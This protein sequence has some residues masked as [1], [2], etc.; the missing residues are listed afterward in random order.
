MNFY[1]L[2]DEIEAG[3][4]SWIEVFVMLQNGHIDPQ[5]IARLEDGLE[6]S[7]IENIGLWREGDEVGP[8]TREE[9]AYLVS[10]GCLD[11]DVEVRVEGDDHLQPLAEV[12]GCGTPTSSDV[13]VAHGSD[14]P[15]T[16][17]N[18]I[19]F[20]RIVSACRCLML[21]FE[22]WVLQ[23][24]LI[25]ALTL[26][27]LGVVAGW[28]LRSLFVLP[29]NSVA[30]NQIASPIADAALSQRGVPPGS[31][32]RIGAAASETILP[33]DSTQVEPIAASEET[34]A[35]EEV[36]QSKEQGAPPSNNLASD[37]PE[38]RPAAPISEDEKASVTP[39]LSH[40]IAPAD[41]SKSQE[42][43]AAPK[44]QA[45]NLPKIPVLQPP[46]SAVR[47]PA[48]PARSANVKQL[49]PFETPQLTS[50]ELED[51]L[52]ERF[53]SPAIK[54]PESFDQRP[55]QGLYVY[56][57]SFKLQTKLV[58]NP[59]VEVVYRVPMQSKTRP[60]PDASNVVMLGIYHG[61]IQPQRKKIVDG[62]ALTEKSSLHG[63]LTPFAD[64]LGYTAF[65]FHIKTTPDMSSDRREY[66]AYG[67]SDWVDLVFRAKAEIEKRHKLQEKK[68]L[69]YGVSEGGQF[70]QNIAAAVPDKVAAAVIQ[71]G[72]HIT[73]PNE[74][75]DTA[76]FL[77][78]TRG[79]AMQSSYEA[80]YN[81]LLQQDANVSFNIF[82]PDYG[83]RG[84]GGNFYHSQSVIADLASR[85]FLRG[86]VDSLDSTGKYNRA[87]WPFVRDRSKPLRIYPSGSEIAKKMPNELKEYLPSKAFAQCLQNVPAQMQSVTLPTGGVKRAKAFVGLP[88]MGKP[89]GVILYSQAFNILELQHM[90][91]NIYFL[92]GL[93]Y[94][95]IAPQLKKTDSVD[96]L[97]AMTFYEDSTALEKFP[98]AVIGYG[99]KGNL[100]WDAV[101][102]NRDVLPKAV[103][104]LEFTPRDTL[105]E[106]N[107]PPGARMGA[108]VV[109]V[110]D[111]YPLIDVATSDEAKTSAEIVTT[112]R[113][114]VEK[115]RERN[116]LAKVIVIPKPTPKLDSEPLNA[117]GQKLERVRVAQLSLEAAES[118]I[119]NVFEKKTSKIER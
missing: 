92:A 57:G 96:F 29:P 8:F 85:S 62:K 64:Q 111:E 19:L 115:C 45:S 42:E 5:T 25:A 48:T 28:M 93:G 12:V 87:K 7:T 18:R 108:P 1:L 101:A 55:A 112:V 9:I 74:T 116:Q 24:K 77:S 31:P 104:M 60:G 72:P 44:P 39:D 100:A 36:S 4:Y 119:S 17:L 13:I 110:F 106:S 67:G 16:I 61:A 46:I 3:P 95:V 33:T 6:W 66:Y 35:K 40:Q 22:Q 23:K 109:F 107:L 84:L 32:Q 47:A 11:G 80:V 26:V 114:F 63:H 88:P 43:L 65:T 78:I 15:Y 103:A 10:E 69:L 76:W 102:R 82:P 79:D 2:Q 86:V 117:D 50:E 90:F 98:M 38:T 54:L 118:F 52:Q 37:S 59:E 53:A 49:R 56:E 75:S 34:K 71:S 51:L 89:K 68:L 27:L 70:A 105:D 94:V 83:S 73:P 14:V 91:D 41:A 20:S 21:A 30:K 99:P 97:A 113:E 81:R 58:N